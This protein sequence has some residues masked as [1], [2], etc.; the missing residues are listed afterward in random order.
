MSHILGQHGLCLGQVPAV[1]DLAI[2]VGCDG[3]KTGLREAEA[4][5]GCPAN[6]VQIIC[7]HHMEARLV[8]VHGVQDNLRRNGQRQILR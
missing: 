5:E 7:L 1:T 6:A 4:L 3:S 8:L 2:L